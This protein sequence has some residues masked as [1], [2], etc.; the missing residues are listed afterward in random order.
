[1]M[2][3]TFPLIALVLTLSLALVYTQ[4]LASPAAEVNPAGKTPGPQQPGWTPGPPH[5][6]GLPAAAQ[7]GLA[8][9]P[10]HFRGIITAVDATSLTVQLADGTSVLIALTP[11]TRIHV[12]GPKAQGD[13]LLVGMQV[14][15]MAF[16]DETAGWTARSV[17]AI[18]GAPVRTH[19][20]GIVSAYTAGV[21]I[22]IDATDGQSYTFV[23]TAETKILPAEQAATLAVGSLVTIIAP[24]DPAALGWTATGIVV[25]P[26]AT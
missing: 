24:R 4:A 14:M 5:T 13:T 23:L 15:V 3:R 20:V 21:S 1:M 9:K 7:A 11:E 2:K 17:M 16:G 6:P 12:P 19:R 22:T 18:P 8:K 25:H 10:A 26:P